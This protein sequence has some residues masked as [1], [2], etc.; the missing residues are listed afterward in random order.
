MI[1]TRVIVGSLLALCRRLYGRA[2][3][4]YALAI[5]DYGFEVNAALT[6]PAAAN[7]EQAL[8]HLGA[9]LAGPPGGNG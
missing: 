6:G 2:P 4:A 3:R 7:L 8:L 9:A 5:P 1:R